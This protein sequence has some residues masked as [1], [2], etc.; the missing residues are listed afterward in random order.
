[1]MR[2]RTIRYR[3]IKYTVKRLYSIVVPTVQ[4]RPRDSKTDI[5][6]AV[7]FGFDV[8]DVMPPG[9]I[10]IVCHIFHEELSGEI[11]G[12]LTNIAF[13]ADIYISTDTEAKRAVIAGVF[14]KWS[15]G[16]VDIRISP[17]IGRD[18]SAKLVTFADIY[19]NYGLILF[20]HSKRSLTITI[21]N[22]WRSTLFRSLAGS[23][24][25][26]RSIL[27][28]FARYPDVGVVM[29]QHFGPV[30]WYVKWDGTYNVAKRL[31]ARM[32]VT[33]TPQH[34]LDFPSGS[35]FWVRPKALEPLLK[36]GLQY[37]DFPR[38]LGQTT[39]TIAHAVERLFLYVCE[40]AGYRWVKIADPAI[41]PEL[42]S[43]RHIDDIEALD[44]FMQRPPATLL[45]SDA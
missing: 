14:A 15:Q 40:I 10:G 16:A 34:R 8:G 26:V 3:G 27:E 18:I 21:G 45:G 41:F 6:L 39:A 36:L 33:I 28:V 1:M 25:T 37:K 42:T 30:D 5:S 9:S 22:E 38:E 17:N 13:P 12:Y 2:L 32:G 23:P 24:E 19:Q 31:A 11:L 7:P 35:M 20:L 4:G 29:S 44:A 43:I